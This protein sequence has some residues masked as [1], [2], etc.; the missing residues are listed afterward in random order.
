MD[1]RL[2]VEEMHQMKREVELLTVMAFDE[3]YQMIQCA[4]EL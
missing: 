4:D 1:C 3:E 2:F